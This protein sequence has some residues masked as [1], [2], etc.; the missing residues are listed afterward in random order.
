MA[1]LVTMTA[2]S[3]TPSS[4]IITSA[5]SRDCRLASTGC[6]RRGLASRQITSNASSSSTNT[7]AAGV[8]QHQRADDCCDPAAA[9]QILR[10]VAP[11][12]G[13][14]LG[15][16]DGG[17]RVEDRLLRHQLA[18]ERLGDRDAQDHDRAEREHRVEGHR[19]SRRRQPVVEEAVERRQEVFA[20]A[21]SASSAQVCHRIGVV[22]EQSA[23]PPRPFRNSPSRSSTRP[24][25]V[26]MRR[27]TWMA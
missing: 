6:S 26:S 12:A 27:P 15:R 3:S 16:H 1:T 18:D 24:R 19:R 4:T 11:D 7:P 21:C 2:I 22:G 13:E 17:E 14:M 8:E 5:S 23:A 25:S 9:E 20:R 10:S